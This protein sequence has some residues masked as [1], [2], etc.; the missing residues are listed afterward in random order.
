MAISTRVPDGRVDPARDDVVEELLR[1]FGADARAKTVFGDPVEH[2]GVQI[3]PV[4]RVGWGFGTGRSGSRRSASRGVGAGMGVGP[5]GYIEI[6][7]GAAHFRRIRPWWV[8]FAYVLGGG[9]LAVLFARRR[10]KRYA[11]R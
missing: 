2:E 1:R 5:A 9:M 10:A 4:A 8:E 6:S 3:I 7:D 11:G